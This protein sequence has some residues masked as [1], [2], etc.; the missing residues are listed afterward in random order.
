MDRNTGEQTFKMGDI[1]AGYSQTT[2]REKAIVTGASAEKVSGTETNEKAI[3]QAEVVTSNANK[4]SIFTAI[5]VITLI[6][7][8]LGVLR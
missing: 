1:Y 4:R 7:V 6:A 3:E 8:V 2:T 5:G